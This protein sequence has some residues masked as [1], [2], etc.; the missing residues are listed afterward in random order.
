MVNPTPF[1]INNPYDINNPLRLL[2]LAA[3][4]FKDADTF[5]EALQVRQ[6]MERLQDRFDVH[7]SDRTKNLNSLTF[8]ALV[9]SDFA[10][11]ERAARKCVSLYQNVPDLNHEKLATYLSMLS[12]VLAER[13]S[14]D[15]AVVYGEEALHHFRFFHGDSDNFVDMV[16]HNVECMR[17]GERRQ[18]IER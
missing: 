18:Y 3:I 4:G 2:Q 14:F 5:V 12:S 16:K 10:E 17:H 6:L 15:E 11:A 1:D 8:L 9:V 7:A 13:G